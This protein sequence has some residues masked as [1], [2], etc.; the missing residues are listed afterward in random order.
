MI[1]I[2]TGT[3][4]AEGEEAEL[5]LT[6]LGRFGGPAIRYR[7]GDVVRGYRDHDRACPFLWLEGGVLGRADDM[8][9]IR[10]VNVFPSSIEA[11]VRE[12]AATTEFRMIASRVEEM[13]QLQIEIEADEDLA[14][15][16]SLL[17]RDRLA[18]RIDVSSVAIG[19]L[20][21]FEAKSRRLIDRRQ[22]TQS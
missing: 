20:P 14:R 10:G 9:V 18:L 22:K 5:V 3:E 15:Q 11:I 7:T 16:L 6:S 8:M 1:S 17:L 13:D 4:A 2:P 21:R 19:T 12:L